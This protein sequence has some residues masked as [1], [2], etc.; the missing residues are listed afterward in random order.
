MNTQGEATAAPYS[1]GTGGE[2]LAR[3]PYSQHEA[4]R[5]E[6]AAS[7]HE[8]PD[9]RMAAAVPARA[10]RGIGADDR[11]RTRAPLRRRRTGRAHAARA[12]APRRAR[13]D[14][15]RTNWPR[16]CARA[17]RQDAAA[18]LRLLD[19]ALLAHG[20]DAGYTVDAWREHASLDAFTMVGVVARMHADEQPHTTMIQAVA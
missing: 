1:I 4:I 6:R 18:V 3:R 15:R 5:D 12:R 9:R 10:G 2:L 7:P 20:R 8:H 16:E 13:P 11:P 19:R 14:R 17:A